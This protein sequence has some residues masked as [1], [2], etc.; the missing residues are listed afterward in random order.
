MQETVAAHAMAELSILIVWLA[1]CGVAAYVAG[2]KGRSG[3]GIFFL[4]FFLKS[5]GR[6]YRRFSDWPQPRRTG[7]EEVPKLRRICSAGR[8]GVSILPA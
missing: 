3:V 7:Q 4:S 5:A 8:K 2:N 1:L 6:T